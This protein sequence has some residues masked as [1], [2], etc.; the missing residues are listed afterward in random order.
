MTKVW[1]VCTFNAVLIQSQII[2][3]LYHYLY[4][5]TCILLPHFL[6]LSLLPSL[7]LPLPLSLLLSLSPSSFSFPLSPP[8]LSH[9]VFNATA[10]V[11]YPDRQHNYVNITLSSN[12]DLSY[13]YL[14]FN[15]SNHILQYSK[16][17]L[18][19]IVGVLSLI[20]YCTSNVTDCNRDLMV[21][22]V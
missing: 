10:T 4:L 17:T 20:L 21:G 19:V 11:V 13:R 14:H 6:S 22:N 15:S 1:Q 2:S 8:S 18:Q 12:T 9:T 16:N 7:P 5:Y 3:S